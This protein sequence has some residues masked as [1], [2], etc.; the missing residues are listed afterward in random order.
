MAK[1]HREQETCGS[2]V[3]AWLRGWGVVALRF[4]LDLRHVG[5]A[6]ACSISL[7][8]SPEP[9]ELNLSSYSSLS[10]RSILLRCPRMFSFLPPR[11]V[12]IALL[13][14]ALACT[15]SPVHAEPD[16]SGEASG[17]SDGERPEEAM[18]E[19][20]FPGLKRL[21][22]SAV[23]QSPRM[24]ARA[25][26]EAAAE[27]ARITARAGQLPRLSGSGQYYP[28]QRDI[29]LRADGSKD[30][31]NSDRL[32]YYL[33]MSQPIY[34]W[35][36]LRNATRI[37]EIQ[38]KAAE[39]QTAETYRL[40]VQ[41]IR[42]QYLQVI[43]SKKTL[44]RTRFSQKLA[45]ADFALAQDK[46]ASKVIAPSAMFSVQMNLDQAKLSTDQAEEAYASAKRTLAKLA[47]APELAD[48]DIPD[49]IPV[50]ERKLALMQ[51]MMQEAIGEGDKAPPSYALEGLHDQIEIERLNYKN[52]KARL[53]PNVDFVLGASQDQQSYTADIG[54]RY[55]VQSFY[56]GVSVS[57]SIFDGFA[58]RG[59]K[60][61]SLARQRQLKQS[62][63]EMSEGLIEQARS[64]LKQVGFA[65]RSMALADKYLV[66]SQ[67]GLNSTKDNVKRGLSSSSDV[68]AAQLNT[69]DAEIRAFNARYDFLMKSAAFFSTLLK[70]PALSSLPR[71][72]P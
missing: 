48:D 34:H 63:R 67:G 72:H 52:I 28:W 40:L 30:R 65:E 35:G 36:A 46:L 57:W 8:R 64:Q 41:A 58:T 19:N 33:N 54:N 45:E 17:S 20:Y 24:I 56:T 22:E 2:G 47:G 37:G 61:S 55:G 53:R 51:S 1:V 11:G 15:F 60:R 71:S 7:K 39:G 14:S 70:D 16:G 26:D 68:D 31:L 32:T 29:R 49:E 44:V 21:L 69:Y 12:R 18:P 23:S 25:A 9:N 62:Y 5:F 13:I 43:I 42:A 6:M 10:F 59:L 27:G 4:V 50:L 3:I 66:A 38:L